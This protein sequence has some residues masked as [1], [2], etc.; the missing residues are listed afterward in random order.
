VA[1]ADSGLSGLGTARRLDDAR[2]AAYRAT[3]EENDDGRIRARL[4][5]YQIRDG[6]TRP[7]VLATDVST[8]SDGRLRR[9]PVRY[10]PAADGV[11]SDRG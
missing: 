8:T 6:Q 5:T 7:T 3:F 10:R 11:R 1:L 2:V 4:T 9:D